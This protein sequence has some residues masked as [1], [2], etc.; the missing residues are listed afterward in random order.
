MKENNK[1]Q[2]RDV[3]GEMISQL[4]L[5]ASFIVKNTGKEQVLS[6]SK[7]DIHLNEENFN[8]F[9]EEVKAILCDTQARELKQLKEQ[10]GDDG[11]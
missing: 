10:D 5:N 11:F 1:L 6:F 2:A 7:K 9:V 8:S 4:Y 3:E